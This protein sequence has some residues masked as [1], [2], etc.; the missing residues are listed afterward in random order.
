MNDCVPFA[1]YNTST[2]KDLDLNKDNYQFYPFLNNKDSDNAFVPNDEMDFTFC[3]NSFT[4]EYQASE[5]ICISDNK[6][7]ENYYS[8]NGGILISKDFKTLKGVYYVHNHQNN[9]EVDGTFNENLILYNVFSD[10]NKAFLNSNL[11]CSGSTCNLNEIC[12]KSN[13]TVLQRSS[14]DL[15]SLEL[16]R[17]IIDSN[18]VTYLGEVL[19]LKG[20]EDQKNVLYDQSQKI[21]IPCDGMAFELSFKLNT[22]TD[23]YFAITDKESFN[24]GED[25]AGVIGVKS[26]EFGIGERKSIYF[27]PLYDDSDV[28]ITIKLDSAGITLLLDSNVILN[29]LSQD[30]ACTSCLNSDSRFLYFGSSHDNGTVQ[31]INIKCLNSDGSCNGN[32]KRD[33]LDTNQSSMIPSEN[34]NIADSEQMCEY[35]LCC[36][37]QLQG[38]KN[39]TSVLYDQNQ[40][41]TIPCASPNFDITFDLDQD[42]DI[43][44]L[45]S[46]SKGIDLSKSVVG[47]IGALTNEF[48]IG[49]QSN[50]VTY[51]LEKNEFVTI[52]IVS[53]ANGITIKADNV[54]VMT[55]KSS[56]VSYVDYLTG[57]E[58][59]VYFGSVEDKISVHC[60]TIRCEKGNGTC[61]APVYFISSTSSTT[62][63]TTQ[64]G[65]YQ[66]P[67]SKSTTSTTTQ[68]GYY[69]L[70]SSS[71]TTSTTTQE[72]YYQLPSSSSTTSTTMKEGYYQLPSSSST[73]STTT[74]E[75]YYQLPSSSSTTSTTTQAGYYQLPSSSTSTS[76]TMMQG[77][78]Q[79]PSSSSTTST[80]TQEGY[81]QLPSSAFTTST[82]TQKGYYQLPSLVSTTSTTTQAGYYQ[83]PSSTSTTSTTTQEGYYQLPSL[84][85][86]TSTTTQEGYYQ[87]SSSSCTTSTT[88]QEGYYQLPSSAFTTSTT[89]QEGYYQLP[90]LVST[91]STT[92][93]EG[94]YQLPSLALTTST[95]IQTGY[96]QFQNPSTIST[97]TSASQQGYYKLPSS[98]SAFTTASLDN[99]NQNQTLSTTSTTAIASLP[100]YS[101]G[102]EVMYQQTT[103]G[104]LNFENS[105][106]SNDD[107]LSQN[108]NY[109]DNISPAAL[110]TYVVPSVTLS[111]IKYIDQSNPILSTA[112][113]TDYLNTYDTVPT[114]LPAYLTYDSS[115]LSEYNILP[116]ESGDL[117][118]EESTDITLNQSAGANSNPNEAQQSN[119]EIFAQN[120]PD[121]SGIV[122]KESL[123]VQNPLETAQ[124]SILESE[125][126][127]VADN[128]IFSSGVGSTDASLEYSPE[129]ANYV[130]NSQDYESGVNDIPL[131]NLNEAD[132]SYSDLYSNAGI[133]QEN[134]INLAS[135]SKYNINL[136]EDLAQ[137]QE[138]VAQNNQQS[139]VYQEGASYVY[140]SITFQDFSA[141]NLACERTRVLSDIIFDS[142]N[143]KQYDFDRPIAIPCREFE[144]SF[145][146]TSKS[147]IYISLSKFDG[148]ISALDYM[149][150][151]LGI[152]SSIYSLK[153]GISVTRKD[154]DEN[155]S[156][157]EIKKSITVKTSENV[158]YISVDGIPKIKY[159]LKS[160]EIS[161]IYIA[162]SVGVAIVSNGV[163]VCNDSEYCDS[164]S[165]NNNSRNDEANAT[166]VSKVNQKQ[167][168]N[169][170]FEIPSMLLLSADKAADYSSYAPL[171]LPCTKGNFT[172][173]SYVS[174]DSDLSIA[175]YDKYEDL[176]TG[177]F[178]NVLVGL[179]SDTSYIKS[180]VNK[181]QSVDGD[182][183]TVNKFIKISYISKKLSVSVNRDLVAE[184]FIS[185]FVFSRVSISPLG[186]TAS[187]LDA[188]IS[189]ASDCQ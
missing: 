23:I 96:Y 22:K 165:K 1:P 64:E 107:Y 67:S 75:G 11:L 21:K 57:S 172:Y 46:D 109:L 115:Y 143:A 17:E 145:N 99:E 59:Y 74:Q 95:T 84:A 60:V 189:C 123:Y 43:Y 118:Y 25:I 38:S 156:S 176:Y 55:L 81:Y 49:K 103:N 12:T 184:S 53:N 137:T 16:R 62:S 163:F 116:M 151:R 90:S 180:G 110:V 134:S 35:N 5:E 88:T 146:I 100:Q 112:P 139:S 54:E 181:T 117:A 85:S 169:S 70:P 158:L 20:S 15:L 157:N 92:T 93:Q 41:K 186:G 131:N 104:Y 47:K 133:I 135:E 126:E 174:S 179:K 128:N 132:Y 121:E 50:S 182:S 178:I 166:A 161:K 36:I 56:D 40:R 160:F 72:G 154:I 127:T 45:I 97:T 63:T 142:P 140:E 78:Y 175:L 2:I 94:Y 153:K 185:N 28:T 149:E 19:G 39:L 113:S 147:D 73:T 124:L 29:I 9:D 51:A 32:I 87:L 120:L 48:Y 111:S 164:N 91:T 86:T 4:Q 141:S 130:D 129:S 187:I 77:Y 8:I 98:S 148:M 76:T 30:V 119:A 122:G 14:N 82:T 33:V 150:A 106:P 101:T 7:N 159:T 24:S 79:L 167:K 68:E 138:I 162:P 83:L 44:F 89:T 61:D 27:H 144:F 170:N 69:Q 108:T 10:S 183:Q 80:T 65:Y 71:P 52:Q 31:E 105:I 37:D 136:I 114:I 152:N 177:N 173:T 155:I 18:C 102:L 66:L 171:S 3:K 34:T 168:C 6:I 125:T 58:K 13:E 26:G 188:A 42:S